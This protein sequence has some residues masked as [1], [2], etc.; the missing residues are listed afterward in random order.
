MGGGV[1]PFVQR[2]DAEAV[3]EPLCQGGSDSILA[4]ACDLLTVGSSGAW[5]GHPG[6]S[7]Q[8]APGHRSV[9][10]WVLAAVWCGLE[11]SPSSARPWAPADRPVLLRG[12]SLG[13][14]KACSPRAAELREGW[15]S[16]AAPGMCRGLPAVAAAVGIGFGAVSCRCCGRM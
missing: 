12:V 13:D 5:H 6:Q 10:C 9:P 3:A 4:V 8:Q 16:S 7:C 15:A 14:Q 2:A 1:W 11:E